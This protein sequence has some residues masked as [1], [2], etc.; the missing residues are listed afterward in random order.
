[1]NIEDL[2][3][4]QA[5]MV[6]WP[7]A[8]YHADTRT[9]SNSQ[10]GCLRKDGPSLYYKRHEART[11]PPDNETKA[12]RLGTNIHLAVLEPEEW[13]RRIY[14]PEPV[15]T[16]VAKGTAGKGTRARMA[17]DH[18]KAQCAIWRQ[19]IQP[20]AIVLTQDD[21]ERV[22]PIVN[23]VKSH[24]QA[25]PL[26]DA[27]GPC[28]QTVIWREPE[29]G[30]LIRVRPDKLS[31]IDASTVVIVDLKTTRDKPSP[32]EFG[33]AIAKY[34]Y[35]RQGG[36]YTD[37]VQALYPDRGVHFVIIAVH[38]EPDYEVAT[39]ELTPDDELK[40]GREQYKHWLRDL[41]R[42]RE[43]NDWLADWQT[44]LCKAETPRWVKRETT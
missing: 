34:G 12:K 4:G 16:K 9:R 8:D 25:K 7:A 44:G 42:R 31:F 36:L 41:V 22:P 26:L 38:S 40:R 6:D 23:A 11:I 30:V 2:E 5:M 24:P 35:D 43:A 28:E 20:W 15:K 27:E 32:R 39:Y 13:M 21:L 33:M 1:M 37:A 3:P 19:C 18:W 17:Y 29:T 10:I 14:P